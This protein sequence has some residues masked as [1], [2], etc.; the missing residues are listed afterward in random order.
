M[1]KEEV[2]DFIKANTTDWSLTKHL[3]DVDKRKD[4]V[5][6]EGALLPHES[7]ELVYF[8]PAPGVFPILYEL[9]ES[10][11]EDALPT[12]RVVKHSGQTYKIVRLYLR[13]DL[14]LR[15]I[16]WTVASAIPAYVNML[17]SSV[18]SAGIA[19]ASPSLVDRMKVL[20]A[21]WMEP[22]PTPNGGSTPGHSGGGPG[23]GPG[24]SRKPPPV[25]GSTLEP[26]W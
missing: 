25:P 5:W 14:I 10:D 26:I 16:S 1:E 21:G 6:V 13:N 22:Q 3:A 7:K 15:Q 12:D 11:F 17:R 24:G 9:R 20:P 23:L 4:C 2:K 8:A 19:S 18:D